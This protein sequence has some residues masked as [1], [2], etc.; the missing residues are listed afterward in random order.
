MFANCVPYLRVTDPR[1]VHESDDY[2]IFSEQDNMRV[3]PRDEA[4]LSSIACAALDLDP[5]DTDHDP[6]P[7]AVQQRSKVR[8]ACACMHACTPPT[9]TRAQSRAAAQQGACAAAAP[10]RAVALRCRRCRWTT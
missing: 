1:E 4:A 9:T 3:H 10:A 7:K 8:A 6:V 5:A 2:D